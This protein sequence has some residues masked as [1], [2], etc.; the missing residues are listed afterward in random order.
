MGQ[1][2]EP[3]VRLRVDVLVVQDRLD[4]AQALLA[5]SLEEGA[6]QPLGYRFGNLRG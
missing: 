4:E 1:S 3:L 2:A 6:P 5:R